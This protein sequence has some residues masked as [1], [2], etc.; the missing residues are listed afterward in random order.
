MGSDMKTEQSVLVIQARDWLRKVIAD[1]ERYGPEAAALVDRTR[2]AGQVEAEIAALRAQGWYERLRLAHDRALQLLDEAAR[3]ARRNGLAAPLAEVLVSRGAIR[4]E[5]GQ[6]R[7]AQRDFDRAA[8]ILGRAFDVD[9]AIQQAVLY[10]NTG[11]SSLAGGL[12]RR[13]LDEPGAAPEA[14]AKAAN[15]LAMIH[16][17]LGRYDTAQSYFDQAMAFAEQVGP[18]AVAMVVENRAWAAVQS[19]RLIHGLELFEDAKR[20][21]ER[22]GLP[23][24]EL[25]AEYAGAL[26]DL[27]LLPEAAEQASRALEDLQ[28]RGL[29][30]MAAEAELQV[31]RLALL[32]A[33]L[34]AAVAAAEGAAERLRGQGRGTW[35]ARARLVAVEAR[36]LDGAVGAAD[37]T[38]ARRAAVVLTRAGMSVWATEAHLIAGRVART[39]GRTDTAVAE[40]DQ[41]SAL[42]RQAPLLVRVR[43]QLAAALAADLR[44]QPAMVLR[45]ARAGLADLS[46]HRAAL[47]SAELRALASGHGAELG[48]LG[49]GW[50]LRSG[51]PALVLD[52]MERTRATAQSVLDLLAPPGIGDEL[53]ELRSV[54]EEI[55]R[56]RRAGQVEPGVLLARQAAIEADIRR[57]SWLQEPPTRRGGA[58]TSVTELRRAMDGRVLVEFDVLDGVV[59]AAVLEARRTRVVR[60]CRMEE[61][62][63]QTDWL[64][65]ALRRMTRLE[66]RPGSV[67]A[68][69]QLAE[70]AL[71]ALSAM[72]IAPLGLPDRAGLVISPVGDLQRTPWAALTDEP[73]S[74]VPSAAAWVRSRAGSRPIGG[75]VVLVAGPELPGA[76]AE[77]VEL[78][79]LYQEPVVLVPPDSTVDVVVSALDGVDLAHL[80]CHGLIRTDNPTF[81]ALLLADG[82]L[83]LYEMEKGGAPP[84]RIVLAACRSANGTSYDGNETLGFVSNLLARGT[85]GLIA[86][87]VD[88]PDQTVTPLLRVLHREMR[89]APS[90]GDALHA[91]KRAMDP[92]QPTDFVARCA[93]SAFGA[94]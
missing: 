56:R 88:V 60:A 26:A 47:P 63:E 66:A 76:H 9:L 58:R 24:D 34:P 36:L 52:W 50:L 27:R 81:S 1:P 72:L 33:D 59:V 90:L 44:E 85:A 46:R 82:Q 7:A 48:R 94:G 41:A 75:R 91:A 70:S 73:V 74:V 39:L 89:Q 15:N 32:R 4:Q 42:T 71:S 61:V 54:Q 49:L 20:R 92:E 65:F 22:V 19:G 21:C 10:Q 80:A 84:H 11:R 87:S 57:A 77:V 53:A 40:W 38:V 64:L 25:Y 13:I 67:T 3:L 43:G 37:L 17:E 51:S 45:H 28:R 23:L 8:A 29:D 12:Y 35:A 78:A 16:V 31:A 68:A 86:S 18:G 30:L 93:F 55:R 69:R 2:A 6:V 5:L 62:R 79:A 83:S 14:T